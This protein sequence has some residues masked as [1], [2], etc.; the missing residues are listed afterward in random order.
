MSQKARTVYVNSYVLPHLDY[1]C[2]VWG[3]TTQKNL[4]KLFRLQKY[5]ARLVFDD[6]ESNS[7]DLLGKLKWLPINHRIDFHKAVLVFKSLNGLA[8]D[9]LSD[10]FE[11]RRNSH[12][13]FRSQ[14]GD[15]M[16]LVPKPHTEIYK[17]SLAYSGAKLWNTL[18]LPIKQSTSLGQFKKSCLQWFSQRLTNE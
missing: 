9:Y 11:F 15:C 12:Y 7:Q 17:K 13:M 5:A 8:P 6:F 16:L 18:P 14:S 10:Y 1:C 2:T 3:N 4:T